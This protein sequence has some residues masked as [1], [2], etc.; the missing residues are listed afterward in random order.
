MQ[1]TNF[2]ATFGGISISEVVLGP[3]ALAPFGSIAPNPSSN[4]LRTTYTLNAPEYAADE[5][6][7]IASA[8][9]DVTDNLILHVAGGYHDY[10][11]VS[12]VVG[13]PIGEAASAIPAS[14]SSGLFGAQYAAFFAGGVPLSAVN[15]G[16]S[17]GSLGGSIENRVTGVQSSDQSEAF[18][19]QWTAEI[20]LNSAFDGP[21]NFLVAANYIDLELEANYY[22]L[23]TSL[24]YFAVAGPIA[25]GLY[26]PFD[27][28]LLNDTPLAALT[29]YFGSES[30]YGLESTA[31]F[32][33]AYFEPTETL[34]F[35]A[36]LR[37]NQDKKNIRARSIPLISAVSPF[38]S[39]PID[40]AVGLAVLNN[41]PA[42]GLTG[43]PTR[44][45]ADGSTACDAITGV[46]CDPWQIQDATFEEFTGRFVVDWTPTIGFTDDTLV[47]ASYSRGYKGGGF[48][49]PIT[50]VLS[51]AGI[52]PQFEPEFIDAFEIGTKNTL[53]DQRLQANVTAFYYDYEGYQ[54]SRIAART[55]INDNIDAKI[56]GVEGEF[57]LAPNENWL[58]NLTASYLNTEAQDKTLLN[59][60]DP[61]NGEAGHVLVKD[62]LGQN[63]VVLNTDPATFTATSAFG[64]SLLP[65]PLDLQPAPV[66]TAIPGL[67]SPG[68]VTPFGL[69]CTPGGVLDGIFP[70][71]VTPGIEVDISGNELPYSPEF[72][73][74]LGGQY[75]HVLPNGLAL[76]GRTDYYWQD[77]SWAKLFNDPRTDQ[78]ESWQVWNAQATLYGPEERWYVRGFVQNILDDDNITFHSDPTDSTGLAT[79]FALLDPRTYGIE[80]GV[81]F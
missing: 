18:N 47:Y 33:E 51:A 72:T 55:A 52:P 14:L 21:W 61:T 20:R 49:P 48:N 16:P 80:I 2:S 12:Y 37:W 66:T 81:N 9:Y 34:K 35:T 7:F 74:S 50:A 68:A 3:L 31:L 28:S 75:T 24:D 41:G 78:I 77:E 46:G 59:S 64:I 69:D 67:N 11:V 10:S 71:L 79:S 27:A 13:T 70:G 58:F 29:P 57:V 15:K 8:D 43:T 63:C 54:I 62:W 22:V 53:F 42:F 38:T 4:D 25:F 44:F 40:P 19:E 26:N 30:F 65:S 23:S 45:D 76:V 5:T 56:W 73:V 17:T 6:L 39:F 32:G 60:R 1:A 36:G